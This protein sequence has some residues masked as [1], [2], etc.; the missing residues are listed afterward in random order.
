MSKNKSL[1]VDMCAGSELCDSQGE[2]LSIEGADISELE[3]GRGR[4]N[5]N[6]GKSYMSSIGRV[7][8]AKKI[9]KAEDCED[10]RQLYYWD[11]IKAPYLYV[12]G[13]LYNDEDHSN[14]KAAAAILRNIHKSDCPLRI[15]ASVEGGVISRG[16]KDPNRLERTKVH[17]IALT[18]TP[19]NQ[20]T[21]VE[22][23]NLSKSLDPNQNKIDE[24]LIKSVIHL[25][26]KDEE[27][28]SFRHVQR[29]AQAEKIVA[30][31]DKIQKLAKAT[32]IEVQFKTTDPGLLIKKAIESKVLSNVQKIN[33]LMKAIRTKNNT[34]Y[35]IRQPSAASKTPVTPQ[36]G[37]TYNADRT[38]KVVKPAQPA[39]AKDTFHND[40]S[41]GPLTENTPAGGTETS[42]PLKTGKQFVQRQLIHSIAKGIHEGTHNIN[43]I[44]KQLNDKGIHP[45][46]VSKIIAHL[47]DYS[48]KFHKS[49]DEIDDL[50]KALMAGTG[51]AG[52]PTDLT[53]GGVFQSESLEGDGRF[54][55]ITCDN[56][57]K[58]Q[59]HSK[60]QVK[61]RDCGKNF[62]LNKLFNTMVQK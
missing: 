20:A 62:S 41:S 61:C 31:I 54:K 4:L 51:G 56:C 58:E 29:N 2:T 16:V 60:H 55:Y 12:K 32:G 38:S 39:I 21:L 6:H 8:G 28:P 25:A 43:D 24:N 52:A 59:I 42:I 13:V 1:E 15:K 40:K 3:A 45:D 19:A 37:K 7:T 11:K 22:P 53:G 23:L 30:N 14:A 5:D 9:F 49:I 44:Q 46:R 18:F 57:G 35:G 48:S 27:I 26:K 33:A 36:A 17:S 47:H 10:E 50:D 34:A